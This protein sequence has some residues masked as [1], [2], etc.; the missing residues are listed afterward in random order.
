MFVS[1][2]RLHLRA[3]R[4]FVPFALYTL[5][6]GLQAKRSAGFRRGLVGSDAQGGNW[7][8]TQWIGEADMRAFRNAGAHRIAMQKLI[9]WCDEASFAHYTTD[10]IGLPSP[11]AAYARLR[12]GKTSKVKHP[13]QAHAAGVTVSA[14]VPRFGLN[15]R[16][17]AE[18][19]D[20]RP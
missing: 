9:D 11:E 6:S 18:R 8:I 14:G 15:L 4:F 10:E 7:T 20:R 13:S 2:T 1:V 5:R 17:R 3:R 19:P 12:D 16:P